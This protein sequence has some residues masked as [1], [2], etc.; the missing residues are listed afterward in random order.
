[1]EEK[2]DC[3]CVP[4]GQPY[5]RYCAKHLAEHVTHPHQESSW[6][7]D[8]ERIFA[9]FFCDDCEKD[10]PHEVKKCGI[11]HTTNFYWMRGKLKA[12]VTQTRADAVREERESLKRSLRQI[13]YVDHGNNPADVIL[14]DVCRFIEPTDTKE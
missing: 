3:G 5:A 1:M 7:A 11:E 6:A 13:I 4:I 14:G 9:G 2:K 8:L 10:E 12:F